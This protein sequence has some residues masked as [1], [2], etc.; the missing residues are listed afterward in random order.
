MKNRII[1]AAKEAAAAQGLRYTMNDLARNLG[2]SKRTLYEHFQSKEELIGVIVDDIIAE[3]EKQK[4]L[5]VNDIGLGLKEKIFGILSVQP[6]EWDFDRAAE[7]LKRLYPKEWQK[8]DSLIEKEWD[9]IGVL[10]KQ[11]VESGIFRSIQIPIAQ[12]IMKSAVDG[13]VDYRFLRQNQTTLREALASMVDMLVN[14]IAAVRQDN[15]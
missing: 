8:F 12:K 4:L 6:A 14:G 5:I 15:G 2:I 3:M 1:N 7:D 9:I 11:G 10:L 13:L